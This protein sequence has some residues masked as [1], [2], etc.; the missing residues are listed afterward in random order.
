MEIN[1]TN[2]VNELKPGQWY[3]GYGPYTKD[4]YLLCLGKDIVTI[5]D[6]NNYVTHSSEKDALSCYEGLTPIDSKDLKIKVN[7]QS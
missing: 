6:N 5:I 2:T 3:L 4:P 7:L 1:R